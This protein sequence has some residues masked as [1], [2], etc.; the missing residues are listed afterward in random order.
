MEKVIYVKDSQGK[1]EQYAKLP[2]DMSL[3]EWAIY[4][5][6]KLLLKQSPCKECIAGYRIDGIDEL[7]AYLFEEVRNQWRASWS[8]PL[9]FGGLMDMH[10]WLIEQEYNGDRYAMINLQT[11]FRR[12]YS[13]NTHTF[14]GLHNG[15]DFFVAAD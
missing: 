13:A 12:S 8:D 7:I 6:D 5:Q 2:S 15:V 9:D 14:S 1:K 10:N 11:G 4:N 3:M